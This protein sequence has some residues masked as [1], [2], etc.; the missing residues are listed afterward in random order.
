M[1]GHAE[2]RDEKQINVT[3]ES[4]YRWTEKCEKAVLLLAQGRRSEKMPKKS[5]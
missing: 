3:F 4:R 2:V 5:E 1:L